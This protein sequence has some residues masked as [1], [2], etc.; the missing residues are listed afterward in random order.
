MRCIRSRIR[1]KTGEQSKNQ[2]TRAVEKLK[3]ALLCVS[4]PSGERGSAP[5]NVPSEGKPQ[6]AEQRN[7]EPGARQPNRERVERP[8]GLPRERE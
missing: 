1:A 4:A 5:T 2:P 7:V 3:T 8:A 6:T